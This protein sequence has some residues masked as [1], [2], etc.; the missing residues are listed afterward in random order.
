MIK[1]L[2]S[3]T[4]NFDETL[5]RLLSQRKKGKIFNN[6]GEAHNHFNKIIHNNDL[7]MIKGSNA[8]GLNQFSKNI[9]KGKPNVI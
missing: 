1:V 8:T 4:K 6:L 9:K 2:D 7:L 5:N 3:K